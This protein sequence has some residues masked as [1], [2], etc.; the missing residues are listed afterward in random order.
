MPSKRPR[1]FFCLLFILLGVGGSRVSAL[2]RFDGAITRPQLERYL[3]RAVTMEGVLT[4]H[5]DL[6]NQI[7][8]LQFTGT[9][10]AGRAIAMWGRERNLE[11]ALQAAH[12][13]ERAIHDV[14]PDL[15]LQAAIFEIVT[16]D[17]ASNTL[18]AAVMR[19]FGL[20]NQARPFELEAMLFPDGK[21]V[22]HW[23]NNSSVPDVTQLE[24]RMWIYYLATRYIDLG[25]EAI[26]FGQV[27]LMGAKDSQYRA[28]DDVISRVRKYARTHARRGI[29]VC[30]A[31]VPH[32][33]ML[34]GQRLL[35]DFHSFPLRIVE[36]TNRPL[37][38][39]LRLG[40][41]D[42]LYG[43]S[44]GGITPSGWTCE[45]LPYLV[46][47]D[48][49]GRS[50]RAGQN[51]GGPWIWGYDEICWFARMK[52]EER[53]SWLRYAWKWVREHDSNGFVQ[54]PASR[55][56][57]EPVDGKNW[58]WASAPNTACPTGFDDESTIRDIWKADETNRR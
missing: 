53:D 30:D 28:W 45:H 11:A 34:T 27:D 20:T 57:A 47:F 41:R 40:F 10:F 56:M 29:V 33:G 36:V 32:G 54:M 2:E 16:P 21:F 43:R 37:E 31:H 14:M 35:L 44:K 26:H 7:R 39:E 8:F 22:N 50:R 51:I 9:R 12:P 55:T 5:G 49:F 3:S 13:R 58:Y 1:N 17:V 4:E 42:S 23:R 19:E 15:M 46:E 38:G 25:V 24:T 18:P 48:N 6:T 52:K